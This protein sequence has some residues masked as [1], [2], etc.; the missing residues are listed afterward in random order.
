MA[1]VD[2]HDTSGSWY[3]AVTVTS[4]LL[5]HSL[6]G[7]L[8]RFFIC[9]QTLMMHCTPYVPLTSYWVLK[10]D[11]WYIIVYNFALY[12]GQI[13]ENRIRYAG[14]RML[15]RCMWFGC[16]GMDAACIGFPGRLTFITVHSNL[17]NHWSQCTLRKFDAVL[18]Y[19]VMM[20]IKFL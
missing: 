4:V 16:D 18:L 20:D 7:Y 1:R 12:T 9:G 19:F 5:Y 17:E 6:D 2:H 14:L 13:L 11:P 15:H 3:H 8:C 10:V